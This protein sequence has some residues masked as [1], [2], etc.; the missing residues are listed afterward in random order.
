MK[1]VDFGNKLR[2]EDKLIALVKY[3]LF[4]MIYYLLLLSQ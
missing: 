3:L 1:W 2:D 4:I